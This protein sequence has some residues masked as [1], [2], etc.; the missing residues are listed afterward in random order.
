MLKCLRNHFDLACELENE[1]KKKV[2]KVNRL[3]ET[4]SQLQA[5]LDKIL[6]EQEQWY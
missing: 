1:T 4:H 3:R 6:Y 2:S 5:Q